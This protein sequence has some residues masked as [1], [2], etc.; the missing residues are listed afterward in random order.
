MPA[1]APMKEPDF[2]DEGPASNAC[3]GENAK[4]ATPAA[5]SSALKLNFMCPPN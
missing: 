1:L 4:A 2:V 3:A 5:A